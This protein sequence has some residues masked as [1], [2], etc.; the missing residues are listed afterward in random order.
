MKRLALP[1]L[2]ALIALAISAPAH[3]GYLS[4][5]SFA[6]PGQ[7]GLAFNI[8]AGGFREAV[9]AGEFNATLNGASFLTYC[10]DIYQSFNWGTKYTDYQLTNP[11]S[12]LAWLTTT[13]ANDIGRLFT[14][15][16]SQVTNAVNSS[17]F[18][19]A[20]WEIVN[21]NA[22]NYDLSHGFFTASNYFGN[23]NESLALTT[24]QSWLNALP[25]YSNYRIQVEVSP[26]AQDMVVANRVPEPGS[27]AL[28]LGGLGI[29]GAI[30]RRRRA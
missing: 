24:A 8:R 25:S 16:Q 14:G 12:T 2:P 15:Y 29:V 21:E 26:T 17:A 18:Q 11:N 20:L 3:A 23:A 6:E 10:V 30:Q 27:L 19:L 28:L 13:K 5:D 9:Y 22:A 7:Y 4:I 1:A